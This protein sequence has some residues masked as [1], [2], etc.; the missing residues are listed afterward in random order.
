MARRTPDRRPARHVP[1]APPG[2]QEPCPCGLPAAYGDCCRPLHTGERTA[3]TAERLMRSRYSAFATGDTA[4]LL[5]TWAPA[6][7]PARLALD[8]AMRWT[9][10]EITGA[11]DGSLFHSTGTVTFTARYTH[12]G[13]SGALREHSRFEKDGGQWVYVDGT[14]PDDRAG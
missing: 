8:R 4:Y 1:A 7:R 10:L 11:T 12:G 13:E 2:P 14:F 9:G 6:T 5:R 3:P